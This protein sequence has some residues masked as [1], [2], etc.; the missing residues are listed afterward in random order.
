MIIKLLDILLYRN[1][2]YDCC[3]CYIYFDRDK[4]YL[5]ESIGYQNS[6]YV[7]CKDCIRKYCFTL[8]D[9]SNSDLILTTENFKGRAI[10]L[11]NEV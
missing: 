6:T 1:Y 10:N 8:L 4:L 7:L 3:R 5:V 2:Q 11:E 9:Y